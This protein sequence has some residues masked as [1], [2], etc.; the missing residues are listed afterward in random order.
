M[1]VIKDKISC[2]FCN[3]L[4]FCYRFTGVLTNQMQYVETHSMK[5]SYTAENPGDENGSNL[6][7]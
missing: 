6:K 3:L 5:T 4:I 2:L 1:Y 7:R